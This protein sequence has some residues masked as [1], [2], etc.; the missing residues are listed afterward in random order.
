MGQRWG[1]EDILGNLIEITGTKRSPDDIWFTLRSE[2]ARYNNRN[3]VIILEMLVIGALQTGP[4]GYKHLKATLTLSKR[5]YQ[6][7]S[8]GCVC[9]YVIH[10]REYVCACVSVYIYQY[11]CVCTHIHVYQNIRYISVC[12]Y[13]YMIHTRVHIC[14]HDIN[15]YVYICI[16]IY[17]CIY[18]HICV[19]TDQH[20]CVYSVYIIYQC[21]Y[22]HMCI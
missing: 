5:S 15:Q 2:R 19:Y 11:V 10:Q 12:I 7:F 8:C 20:L 18:Q 14:L 3:R 16:H 4:K 1:A 9:I 22:T 21:V 17:V 6:L 13:V